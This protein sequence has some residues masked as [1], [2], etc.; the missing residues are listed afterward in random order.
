MTAHQP[1]QDEKDE[2]FQEFVHG[3]S[4][5][6]IISLRS[7]EGLNGLQDVASTLVF[8]ELDWSPGVH[9]QCE[10]RLDRPGQTTPVAAFYMTSAMGSDPVVEDVLR[11]KLGQ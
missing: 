6:M 5:L 9:E 4:R 10:A 3:K 11:E 1:Q 8:G 7:G 2:A